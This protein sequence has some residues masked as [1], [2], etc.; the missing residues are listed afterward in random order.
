MLRD[1]QKTN[2]ARQLRAELTDC[3]RILW[4]ELRSRR[5]AGRKFRR[6]VPIGP[7]IAD[8]VCLDA[9][10]VIELDGGQH[11]ESARDEIRD[12]YLKSAGWTVLRFWNNDMLRNR[13][14]VLTVISH[15]LGTV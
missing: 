15:T 13:E 2:L 7:Y 9:K 11:S 12:A 8:F 4:R 6:Q 14:G 5:F 10:L 3:E 1:G